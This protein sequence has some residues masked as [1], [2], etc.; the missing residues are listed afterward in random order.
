MNPDNSAFRIPHSAFAKPLRVLIVED[1]E[2]DAFLVIRE[3]RR[4][5]Y[6][7]TSERV[8]TPEAMMSSLLKHKWDIVISDYVLPRF[9]GHGALKILKDSGLDLPF[10]IV[11][12]NIGEDIAVETMKM[13]ASDYIIKGNLKRL[14]PAVE[15]ELREAEKKIERAESKKRLAASNELFRLFSQTVSR[16]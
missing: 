11:S 4:G 14:V 3:L 8:E 10:I 13:G 12:G 1:S 7:P 15:R 9:S 2:D 16:K 5:G 6:E